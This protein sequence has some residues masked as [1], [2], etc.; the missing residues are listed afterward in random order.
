[1]NKTR[2]K[3]LV[4]VNSLLI[5][6]LCFG[7][8]SLI[9]ASLIGPWREIGRDPMDTEYLEDG[10]LI[11]NQQ[12]ITMTMK[13]KLISGNRLLWEGM[14]LGGAAVF[15]YKLSGNELT[16]VNEKN[17][18]YK[19][20]FH[21]ITQADYVKIKQAREFFFKASKAGN[22]S[23]KIKYIN[24]AIELDPYEPNY[25]IIRS[26][27]FRETKERK[28]EIE[29]ITRAL[30]FNT[31]NAYGDKYKAS[32]YASRSLAY[33]EIKEFVRALEDMNEAVKLEPQEFPGRYFFI[34]SYF[35]HQKNIDQAC[36]YFLK[37]IDMG[38][39][40]WA[41]IKGY[42]NIDNLRNEEC[43]KKIMHNK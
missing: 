31:I 19:K 4:G 25:Y 35:S 12:G 18:A 39:N 5:F 41:Y 20:Y 17:P 21:R 37:A 34:S 14:P 11:A 33:A 43:Y 36:K 28:K 22:S 38:Y 26:F 23:E 15:N 32:V 29:D 16:L 1:M 24:Q 30:Q 13:Y 40:N 3:V 2:H 7:L 27:H 8:T 10:T 42:R 6:L 9:A